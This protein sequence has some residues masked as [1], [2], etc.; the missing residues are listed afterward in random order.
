MVGYWDKRYRIGG[1]SGAGSYGAAAQYKARVLRDLVNALGITS[2]I[3]WG[4]GDGNQ[5]AEWDPQCDYLGIDASREAV[6]MCQERNPG[7]TIMHASQYTWQQADAAVSIEVIFHLTDDDEY[8][9]YM[10]RL[11]DSARRYVI[12]Y[13]SNRSGGALAPHVRHRKL[14]V[15]AGWK[16]VQKIAGHPSTFSDFYVYRRSE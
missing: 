12:I 3:D 11:F 16:C 14:K 13:S 5:L 4:C 6:R 1:T 15:P 10:R 8:R 7:R 9:E 2:V